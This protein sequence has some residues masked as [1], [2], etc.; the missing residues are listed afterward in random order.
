MAFEIIK[1]TYLLTFLALENAAEKK[2]VL[3]RT[4][5]TQNCLKLYP[6][7]ENNRSSPCFVP[8]DL[9]DNSVHSPSWMGSPHPARRS[10]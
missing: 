5:V 10:V 6:L 4:G 7:K 8:E 9:V 2:Q 1:L 3:S